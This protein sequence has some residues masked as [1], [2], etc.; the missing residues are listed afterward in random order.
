MFGGLS[1]DDEPEAPGGDHLM[2]RA[3]SSFRENDVKRALRAIEAAGQKAESLEIEGDCLKI[4][5]QIQNVN[6]ADEG[7]SE[8]GMNETDEWDEKYGQH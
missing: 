6:G 2:G 8:N 1:Q 7:T 4:K 5:F 3:P